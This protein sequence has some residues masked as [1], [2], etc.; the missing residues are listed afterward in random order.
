MKKEELIEILKKYQDNIEIT[1]DIKEDTTNV[2]RDYRYPK[3]ELRRDEE[4]KPYINIGT[5]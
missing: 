5:Y 1:V 4:G 2:W 3:I